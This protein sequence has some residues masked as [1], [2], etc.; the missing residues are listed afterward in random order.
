MC[1]GFL[2][3]AIGLALVGVT[4]FR[5]AQNT[6]DGKTAQLDLYAM[7]IMWIGVAVAAVGA[8]CYW[9]HSSC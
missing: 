1:A 4:R 2:V 5:E 8:T 9:C 3:G 7:W 6:Y